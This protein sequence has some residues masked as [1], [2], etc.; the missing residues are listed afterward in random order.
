MLQ[1]HFQNGCIHN[2]FQKS[3]FNDYI[4][5][6]ATGKTTFVNLTTLAIKLAE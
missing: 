2:D 6:I 5:I 3:E 1:I 4:Q